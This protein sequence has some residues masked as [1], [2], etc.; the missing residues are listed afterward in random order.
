MTK[1][2][3]FRVSGFKVKPVDTTGAGDAY[4]AGFVVARLKGWELRNSARFANAVAALK[5][6]RKGATIGLPHMHEVEE[7]MR[8]E[9]K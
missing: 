2:E 9:E 4:N 6:M 8:H 3:A 5:T 7:F 1:E